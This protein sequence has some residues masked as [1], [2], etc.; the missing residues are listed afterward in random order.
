MRGLTVVTRGHGAA[1]R[2]NSSTLRELSLPET[3]RLCLGHSSRTLQ[4]IPDESMV[5]GVIR[6]PSRIS[7]QIAIPELPYEVRIEGSS[8]ILGPVIG[9]LNDPVFYADPAQIKSRF[10]KYSEI[11]GLI[12]IFT[13]EH[14]S[15]KSQSIVGK[16]Y[17]PRTDNF[18]EGVLPFPCALYLRDNLPW[19]LYSVFRDCLG[20]K[21]IYNYPFRSNKWSLWRFAGRDPLVRSH[22]PETKKYVS[23]RDTL[24][25]LSRNGAV[26]LKPFTWSRGR[27]IYRLSREDG[28]FLLK[29]SYGEVWA[30]PDKDSLATLLRSKLKRKYLIQSEIPFYCQ[31]RKTDFRI[32]LQKDGQ[33][34]WQRLWVDMRMAEK[35]S[36]VTNL[37]NRFE[38][39]PGFK[40][41]KLAFGLEKEQAE[42][43]LREV[44]LLCITALKGLEKHGQSLGDVAVDFI[45][46]NNQK[47]WIL[48]V[49]P[50]YFGDVFIRKYLTDIIHPNS[51]AYAKAL[52][53]FGS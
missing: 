23:A 30:A 34:R 29:D 53:G 16:Y 31:G 10:K 8:L 18:L 21:K 12:F 9:F 13:R 1:A 35:H 42:A 43:K 11:G 28:G 7:R 17:D 4:V 14:V 51:L 22:L 5:E 48:E 38:V 52:A 6:L 44:T 40:G 50:D 27:G 26:Y 36:I 49:Q 25:F 15:A 32:Y 19:H 47:P 39:M 45:L 2:M 24:D 20:A 37:R 3:I 33:G 41:L 46:D